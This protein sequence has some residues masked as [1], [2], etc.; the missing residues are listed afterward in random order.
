M[1]SSGGNKTTNLRT[2]GA[3][4][5]CTNDMASSQPQTLYTQATQAELAQDYDE[6]FRLYIRAAEGFLHLSRGSINHSAKSHSKKE[7]G[8]A[9]ERAEMIKS[10]KRQGELRTVEVDYWSEGAYTS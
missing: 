7:A 6:A 10:V 9:L 5:V 4:H 1:V 8:R 2:V 3:C